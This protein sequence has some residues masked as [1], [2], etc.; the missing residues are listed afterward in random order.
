[1]L[2][3]LAWSLAL[4]ASLTSL[5]VAQAA[6]AATLALYRQGRVVS[7]MASARTAAED[8][9][10][11]LADRIAAQ[12]LLLDLCVEAN[13]VACLTEGAP[14]LAALDAADPQGERRRGYY[15]GLASLWSGPGAWSTLKGSLMRPD[16]STDDPALYLRRQLAIAQVFS[17]FD[18]PRAVSHRLDRALSL[19]AA[20]DGPQADSL[21]VS[22][23]LLA[24]ADLLVAANEPERALR[25]LNGAQSEIEAAPG[26]LEAAKLSLV[27]ASALEALG[28]G[29]AATRE[30][31]MAISRIDALELPPSARLTLGF[32]ALILKAGLCVAAG[33]RGCAAAALARHPLAPLYQDGDRAPQSA[34]EI[35]YLA[36][37]LWAAASAGQD[38]R[39]A[40]EALAR[41]WTGFRT[42]ADRRA[43]VYRLAARAA[44]APAGRQRQAALAQLGLEIVAV[45]KAMKPGAP[46]A[47]RHPGVVDR[48]MIAMALSPGTALDPETSFA[49]VQMASRSGP[50]AEA[51]ALTAIGR[52]G[53]IDRQRAVRQLLRI[54]ARRDRI[55]AEA[56]A[57]VAARAGRADA[58]GKPLS[59]SP[60]VRLSI[61][62]LEQQMA[63]L[64]QRLGDDPAALS[65]VNLVALKDF[66]AAL[67]SDEAA[68]AIAQA[69][70]GRAHLCIRRDR[71][72]LAFSTPDPVATRIDGRLVAAALSAGHAASEALDSQFP[73]EAAMRL[74]AATVGPVAGCLADART[75][76]ALGGVADY[77]AP[78][79]V[80]LSK[81]PPK[82]GPG[83]DL[84]QADWFVRR[85][86]I[87][88]AGSP[89]ALVATRALRAPAQPAFDF[90]GVG[91]P[92]LSGKPVP[93][94]RG[95][96]TLAP[97][98]ETR[99]ELEASAAGFRRTRLILGAE[100]TERGFRSALLGEY[101]YLSF[102]THGLL[103]E[104]LPGLTEPALVLTPTTP[105]TGVLGQALG[106]T[107]D[108]L[109][110]AH[111]IAALDLNA[112]FVALSACNT[113]NA[114]LEAISAELPA[115]ASA[116][117]IAGAPSTLGTL[118]PVDTQASQRVT[119]DV[120]R[121]VAAGE[122]PAQALAAAQRAFLAAPPD[123]ARL[124]PR[125][126]APF[127]I[128]GEGGPA[129]AAPA[130]RDLTV[131]ILGEGQGEILSLA[132][133][134]AGLAASVIGARNAAGFA[135]AEV[136]L[137]PDGNLPPQRWRLPRVGAGR[138]IAALGET[139]VVSGYLT[140]SAAGPA[141]VDG[142]LTHILPG[143][144]QPV[145][146][147]DLAEGR[148]NNEV[149]ALAPRRD[150]A[151]ALVHDSTRHRL[152]GVALGPDFTVAPWFETEQPD[153]RFSADATL[154]PSGAAMLATFSY[155]ML[156]VDDRPPPAADDYDQPLCFTEPATGLELR[157]PDTGALVKR[158][159]V[160]RLLVTAAVTRPDGRVFIAGAVS[161]PCALPGDGRAVILEV[162]PDLATRLVY[163]D[164]SLGS[165][166]VRTLALTPD[167]G[168]AAAGRKTSVIDQSLLGG[169]AGDPATSRT[170]GLVIWID[171]AER[172]R[173]RLISAGA[174]VFLNGI[175]VQGP[176]TIVGGSVGGHAAMIR[177]SQG[178]PASN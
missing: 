71:F 165:S 34:A 62:M 63:E 11:A 157:D 98:P 58:A 112:R 156:P 18:E 172:A 57:K 176:Q 104:E 127:I 83:Y 128:L 111:E 145:A 108:G 67:A 89:A 131:E 25:L 36:A 130:A 103:R 113:A 54:K 43:E 38:D 115:L 46:G 110:T 59:Y 75:V 55:E 29:P 153:A 134:P 86:A 90:L 13:D 102:A 167:G 74:H 141:E 65:G 116:F 109:L 44:D 121:R 78:L 177:L 150:G 147:L 143:R 97:L 37:R 7:A 24:A 53:A 17:V 5:N 52:A 160:R 48:A 6:D 82:R 164:E 162:T 84:A 144:P 9:R 129:P 56:V 42:E 163:V 142:R 170:N 107:D 39:V 174:D 45:A 118:W 50:E 1:M 80:L 139:I 173:T 119:A 148:S 64:T 70:S 41:P 106:E 15:E 32:R 138:A 93:G 100:A 125:F 92:V 117:A 114:S 16:E 88:Y 14:Q 31:D 120:F 146:A 105:G 20:I 132:R 3:A 26:S 85:H 49:L 91:D 33:D 124:H 8:A 154:T 79:A 155:R 101:A 73:V 30:A 51:D 21:L 12:R 136:R 152:R 69:R 61:R 2:N 66:Q 72:E 168:I 122:G 40:A 151:L 159:G 60:V 133:T 149:A 137:Y 96:E 166:E 161:L 35:A 10:A 175:D 4:L 178:P 22:Q 171:P 169:A 23:S 95:V 126:W 140:P 68:F 87:A 123:R 19:L 81:A 27:R 158:Q 28:D 99:P 76:V 77:G 94:L 135:E 47:Y